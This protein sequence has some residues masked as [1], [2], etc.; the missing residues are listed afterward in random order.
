[1]SA[2]LHIN[3]T[4]FSKEAEKV[5]C[6]GGMLWGKAAEW[7][8]PT[9]YDYLENDKKTN[10]RDDTNEMFGDFDI[11]AKNL[12]DTFGNLDELCTAER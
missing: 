2:Y 10:H 5:M 7:F 8:E 11:F 1:M 6:V 3:E 9:L 4:L 12:R